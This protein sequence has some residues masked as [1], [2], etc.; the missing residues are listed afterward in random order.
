MVYA[1]LRRFEFWILIVAALSW[2]E[3]GAD[4][5]I[6]RFVLAAIPGGLMLTAGLGTL[7]FP[8]ERGL[9]R[10]GALGALLGVFFSV[11]SILFAPGTAIAL[12]FLAAAGLVS[13]GLIALRET[14]VL[15]DVPDMGPS[16]RA[17]IETG[18]DEAVLGIANVLMPVFGTGEQAR[19]AGE[20][21]EALALFEEK[22]WLKDPRSFHDDPPELDAHSVR[23]EK[24]TTAG[25]SFEAL[26]FESGFTPHPELPGRDRYLGYQSC[27][28]AHAWLLRSDPDAPW[29]VCIHGLGM[30][31]PILD[32][33]LL[34]G[35]LFHRDL[36]LNVL[37]PVLPLHGPRKR[38]PVSGR[39][40]LGGDVMDLVNAETQAAWDIRRL[41]SWMEEQGA[42]RVGV[43]G[44]SLGGFNTA[45]ISSLHEGF[46][47]SIAGIPA[48][49]VVDLMWWHVSSSMARRANDE[50]LT[51]EQMTR[52][53]RVV[54]PL[55]MDA[56]VPAERRYIYAGIGDQFVPSTIVHKLWDHWGRPRTHWYPG[57]HLSF[58][59]HNGVGEFVACAVRDT[60][61][62]SGEKSAA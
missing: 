59:W 56:L 40:F 26:S 4:G 48:A 53:L 23:I 9:T 8:G 35:K 45:L 49:D 61:L 29:M 34:Y 60:L 27:R 14:P 30:G 54:S 1:N 6:I 13:C 39:G 38:T 52:A 55:A 11:V 62:A 22:G 42:E 24:R 3:A 33:N 15:D 47:V 37:F 44:M 31:E 20:T 43:H 32:L 7:F 46:E 2:L 25:W 21:R 16:L 10:M 18:M 50:G 17:G 36:G 19:I 51:Q 58:P 5:G 28:K 57:A 12:G 41:V